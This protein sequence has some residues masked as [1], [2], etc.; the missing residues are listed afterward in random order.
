[1][2]VI[3]SVD[4]VEELAKHADAMR[5]EKA[6][7]A[8]WHLA[9][10]FDLGLYRRGVELGSDPD[11]IFEL[12]DLLRDRVAIGVDLATERRKLIVKGRALGFER[13]HCFELP[14]L[15]RSNLGTGLIDFGCRDLRRLAW[16]L[17]EV[18]P[19]H[20]AMLG[21]SCLTFRDR[22]LPFAFRLGDRSRLRRDLQNAGEVNFCHSG[23]FGE[24]GGSPIRLAIYAQKQLP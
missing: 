11:E 6:L 17:V 19:V 20:L 24:H 3:L 7:T 12:V 1:M 4:R 16:H 14:S 9:G 21:L 13:P 15:E 23:S 22:C 8:A 2:M 10:K 18:L 5:T